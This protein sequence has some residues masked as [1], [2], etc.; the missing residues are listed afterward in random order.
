MKIIGKDLVSLIPIGDMGEKAW[1]RCGEFG[2]K[3]MN[4]NFELLQILVNWKCI[5]SSKK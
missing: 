2:L 4:V 1:E 3:Q 5:A